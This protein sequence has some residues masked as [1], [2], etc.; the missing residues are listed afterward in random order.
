[1][2]GDLG[3]AGGDH[4]G[5]VSHSGDLAG[6]QSVNILK[7]SELSNICWDIATPGPTDRLLAERPVLALFSD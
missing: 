1:M 3:L 7:M 2:L 6:E 5:V 4:Q